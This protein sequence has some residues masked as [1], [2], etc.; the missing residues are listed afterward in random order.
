MEELKKEIRIQF[1]QQQEKFTYYVIA[2]CVASVGFSINIT[3]GQPLKWIQLP[4]GI[5]ILLWGA[6]IYLGLKFIQY[7]ISTLFANHAFFEIQEG[8]NP[9]VGNSPSLIQAATSGVK[10]AMETNSERATKLSKWQNR[11]FY[12]G[13]ISFLIWRILE[14]LQQA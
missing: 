4:L 7:V 2:L 1:R 12:F 11:L 6:S 14:M 5:A 13:I 10:Q 8:N 9:E 3:I